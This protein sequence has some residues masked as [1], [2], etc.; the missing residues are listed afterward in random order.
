MW[1]WS[2][3][4][5]GSAAETGVSIFS[6]HSQFLSDSQDFALSFLNEGYLAIITTYIP[7]A[8]EWSEDFRVRVK[9]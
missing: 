5:Q 7:D 3:A 4:A 9:K 2:H 6:L 8:S 1:T